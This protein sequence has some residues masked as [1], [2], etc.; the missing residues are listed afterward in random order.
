MHATQPIARIG[1]DGEK[2][3]IVFSAA[4]VI[5]EKQSLF[6]VDL[7]ELAIRLNRNPRELF[8][9]FKELLR[10]KDII[11]V[12]YA[13]KTQQRLAY[14]FMTAREWVSTPKD[15]VWLPLAWAEG[16]W[17]LTTIAGIERIVA[18][19]MRESEDS[20]TEK[21][22]FFGISP[23]DDGPGELDIERLQRMIEESFVIR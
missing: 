4:S 14:E 11:M 9:A 8:I 7:A 6:F 18:M 19:T 12:E 15:H 16:V 21:Q 23:L 13:G 20:N 17:E 22:V 5:I 1:D 10:P 2:E 3:S